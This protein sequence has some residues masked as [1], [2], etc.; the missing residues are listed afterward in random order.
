M[1]TGTRV[2]TDRGRTGTIIAT[3]VDQVGPLARVRLDDAPLAPE[4]FH[5][6]VLRPENEI[7]ETAGCAAVDAY[8]R[9]AGDW[10]DEEIV[11]VAE[12]VLAFAKENR[13]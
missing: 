3:R 5:P 11:A 9:L 13:S 1:K 6:D 2:T 7:L 12:T 10:A 8:T 4:W